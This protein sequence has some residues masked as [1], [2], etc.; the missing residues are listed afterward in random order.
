MQGQVNVSVANLYSE[1][2]YQSETISQALLGELL[3]VMESDGDFS[4]VKASDGYSGW[5]SNY[6]WL[7]FEEDNGEKVLI[8]SHFAA[9]R[10]GPEP[11]AACLRDVVLGSWLTRLTE[12]KD[13]IEIS[14][15]DGVSG[16]VHK[17][18]TGAI[19]KLNRKNTISIA[20]EF[21]GYPYLW[22]GKSPKGFDCSGLVQ[23]VFSLMGVRLRR[24]SWMQHHDATPVGEDFTQAQ[25]GDLLFFAES[26]NKISHVGIA[27]GDSKILHAR[28]YVKINSLN[29][30]DSLFDQN[31]Q[32][33]FVDVKTC[34]D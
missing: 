13:W 12:K 22:G 18:Q 4:L 27:L 16:W 33:T 8:R 7:P 3:E 30:K 15:P 1:G 23:I 17:T 2:N 14:L 19:S 6:Q 32:N 24:D 25:A 20:K 34:I 29:A 11:D 31:L 28:G 26:N 9:I 21:L 5:I 10:S